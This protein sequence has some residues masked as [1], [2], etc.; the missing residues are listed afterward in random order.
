MLTPYR[1]GPDALARG[2]PTGAGLDLSSGDRSRGRTGHEVA[3]EDEERRDADM[4]LNAVDQGL[5]AYA[6]QLLTVHNR[7]PGLIRRLP[8]AHSN[9]RDVARLRDTKADKAGQV[10]IEGEQLKLCLAQEFGH[11]AVFR[12]DGCDT[13]IVQSVLISVPMRA[14]ARPPQMVFPNRC[15]N[16]LTIQFITLYVK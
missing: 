4:V 11:L 10:T 2:G 6:D 8:E 15:R 7:V 1:I 14:V 3:G 5:E 13:C 16:I 12:G 9:R